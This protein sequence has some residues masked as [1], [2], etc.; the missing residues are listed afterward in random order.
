[1]TAVPLLAIPVTEIAAASGLL[2]AKASFWLQ[3]LFI[4]TS[5]FELLT[6]STM[7]HRD[8]LQVV[9]LRNSEKNQG[10]YLPGTLTYTSGKL[11]QLVV[12]AIMLVVYELVMGLWI[13]TS[14]SASIAARS[15]GILLALTGG[16][17]FITAGMGQ[18]F[19]TVQLYGENVH[20]AMLW[21][22]LLAV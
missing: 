20:G 1:M 11:L 12:P 15:S 3:S 6:F 19:P 2:T 10:T 18:Q 13:L 4:G 22:A 16:I 21:S 8:E 5:F 7:F 17:T 9:D 14:G